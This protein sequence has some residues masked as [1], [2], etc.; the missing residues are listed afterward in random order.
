MDIGKQ[1]NKI[2]APFVDQS[3]IRAEMLCEYGLVQCNE[4]PTC[5]EHTLDLV[6]VHDG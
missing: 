4:D 5:N 1:Y 2:N 6:C 3:P